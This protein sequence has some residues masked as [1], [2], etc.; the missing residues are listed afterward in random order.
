M[1]ARI[2]NYVLDTNILIHCPDSI[3]K[4]DNNNVYITHMTMEELDG[5]KNAPG[6][7]GYNA[8]EAV[9]LINKLRG[10]GKVST[11]VRTPNGGKFYIYTSDMLDSRRLPDGWS[12][13]KPDNIILLMVMELKATKKNVILVTNDAT[14]M[15][16]ADMLNIEAQEYRNDRVSSDKELYTGRT[17]IRVKDEII[18]EYDSKNRIDAK[19]LNYNGELI[20]NQFVILEGGSSSRMG[21]YDGV[22]VRKLKFDRRKPFGVTP[23]NTG[24]YF[25]QEALLTDASDVPLVIMQ[26][27]AGTSKT[28]YSLACGLEQVVELKKYKRILICRPNTKFDDDIGYLKGDEMDKILPLIRPCLDNLEEL[29]SSNNKEQSLD[30]IQDTVWEFFDR[31]WIKAE[32]LA[33]IRGRS[34]TNTFILIDEA[35][36]TTPNQ[37]LGIITR[38][39]TGS[40]IVIVGDPEQIDN[41]RLDKY[42]NGLV[43][44]AEHMKGSKQVMQLTFTDDECTR[45]PLAKEAAERLTIS[46]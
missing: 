42:N 17:T 44:A 33:Y 13:N 12:P 40:K 41:P 31:G 14:M 30:E 45:S 36:N 15:L 2:K 10:K 4:F 24:Q 11:G 34:I 22:Y 19:S 28:F 23:R 26:G 21:V 25:A 16:K 27:A 29:I 1:T 32:A 9:R 5:L 43:Y 46:K 7:T 6:E 8:R 38:A 18:K 35:Q 37:M 3:L 20:T 39:G